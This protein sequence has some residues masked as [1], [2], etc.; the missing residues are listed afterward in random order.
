MAELARR[1]DGA[2]LPHRH[3]YLDFRPQQREPI[4]EAVI[5]EQARFANE[6]P[7]GND[8]GIVDESPYHSG[9]MSES[10]RSS[11]QRCPI[12]A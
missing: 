5:I 11:S 4:A 6:E 1:A 2:R 3:A 7:L 9:P 8:T 10:Q 12:S